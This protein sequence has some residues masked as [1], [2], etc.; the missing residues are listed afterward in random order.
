MP[1]HNLFD[2]SIALT[3]RPDVDVLVLVGTADEF[4]QNG[5]A[6]DRFECVHI[7]GKRTDRAAVLKLFKQHVE[8]RQSRVV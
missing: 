3:L 8:V 4:T 2:R 5:F 6:V 7:V 1:F